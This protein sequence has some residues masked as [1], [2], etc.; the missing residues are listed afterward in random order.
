[1]PS[2]PHGFLLPWQNLQHFWENVYR[3][4]IGDAGLVESEIEPIHVLGLALGVRGMKTGATFL[5]VSG[6]GGEEGEEAFLTT[7]LLIYLNM[8]A[9]GSRMNCFIGFKLRFAAKN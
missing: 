8:L 3:H 7:V 6:S 1:M 2:P 5:S 4:L 9:I